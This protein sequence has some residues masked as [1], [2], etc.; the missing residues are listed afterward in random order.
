M[1]IQQYKEMVEEPYLQ[2]K[3]EIIMGSFIEKTHISCL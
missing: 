1:L 2:L 3:E